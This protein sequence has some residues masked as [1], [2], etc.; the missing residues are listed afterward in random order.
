MSADT[1]SFLDALVLEY[2]RHYCANARALNRRELQGKI[3]PRMA[4]SIRQWLVNAA[5]RRHRKSL[6]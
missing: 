4:A 2:D 1:R 3:E 6:A 5:L